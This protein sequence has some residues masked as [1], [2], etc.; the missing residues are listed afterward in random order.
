M[1]AYFA[2]EFPRN[3]VAVARSRAACNLHLS[4]S[5]LLNT[6]LSLSLPPFSPS[7]FLLPKKYRVER[8][9]DD[10][11]DDDVP[12]SS[13]CVGINS[14]LLALFLSLSVRCEY[15]SLSAF[16]CE[17]FAS[18]HLLPLEICILYFL[19]SFQELLRAAFFHRNARTLLLCY[20]RLKNF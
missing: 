11:D 19:G 13:G 16:F 8:I 5:P 17:R 1:F 4:I 7:S 2:S 14:H 9:N 10:D 20:L 15:R 6:S 12:Y 18:V 3:D